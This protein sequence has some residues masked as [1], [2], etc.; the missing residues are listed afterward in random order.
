LTLTY[1]N[2]LKTPKIKFKIYIYIPNI[3]HTLKKKETQDEKIL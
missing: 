3:K 1:K 2:N